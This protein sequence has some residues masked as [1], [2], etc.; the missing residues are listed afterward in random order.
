L[1]EV[2]LAPYPNSSAVN[3]SYTINPYSYY[4]LNTDSYGR[5]NFGSVPSMTF[6]PPNSFSQGTF[7]DSYGG[8]YQYYDITQTCTINVSQGGLISLLL[9]GGGGGGALTSTS[10]PN[11]SGAGGGEVM[12]VTNYQLTAGTYSVTIGSGGTFNSVTSGNG[13]AGLPTIFIKNTQSVFTSAGGAGGKNV[14]DNNFNGQQ[15]NTSFSILNATSLTGSGAGGITS[16]SPGVGLSLPYSDAITPFVNNAPTIWSYANS[17]GNA[18]NSFFGGGGGAGGPG[19][20][21]TATN[22]GNGGSELHIYFTS[23][24]VP[25]T[26]TSST[27]NTSGGVGGGSAG[28]GGGVAAGSNTGSPGTPPGSNTGSAGSNGNLTNGSAGANGRFIIRYEIPHL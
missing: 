21:A 1:S 3:N 13:G 18:T 23:A 9:I 11:S 24:T 15:G 10:H 19:S 16:V 7:Q 28:T 26:N 20:D 22:G 2:G 5:L 14:N 17:G 8:N 12:L 27:P 25:V 4:T 6:T